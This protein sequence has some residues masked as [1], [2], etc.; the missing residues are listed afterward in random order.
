MR[1]KPLLAIAL[2]LQAILF[3]CVARAQTES[4]AKVFLLSIYRHYQSGG[5]GIDLDGPG[6]SLYFSGSLVALMRA[7]IKANGPDNAPAIDFDP[8][9]GCQDWKGIWGLKI[10]VHLE[11]PKRAHANVSFSLVPPR[12]SSKDALRAMQFTLVPEHGSWHIYDI[13][14]DS[15]SSTTFALRKLLQDDIDTIQKDSAPNPS[16]PP[17]ARSIQ[18]SLIAGHTPQESTSRRPRAPS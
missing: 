17:R 13:E 8:I 10:A 3:C 16:S 5:K 7:D 15:D 9:C 2:L 11:S 4:S 18:P 6:A 12:E 14:D 1:A